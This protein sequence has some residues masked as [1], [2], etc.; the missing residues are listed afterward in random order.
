VFEKWYPHPKRIFFWLK[1]YYPHP[2]TSRVYCDA[3]HKLFVLCLFCLEAI[4]TLSDK[5]TAGII[6]LLAE[7]DWLKLS[8]DKFGTHVL[9]S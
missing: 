2:K 8:H 6:L 7:H 1:S 5:I 4:L 9:L 3:Q